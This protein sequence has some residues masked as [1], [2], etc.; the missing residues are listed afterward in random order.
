MGKQ[1]G[2]QA[3]NIKTYRIKSLGKHNMLSAI[4]HRDTHDKYMHRAFITDET[5][6]LDMQLMLPRTKQVNGELLITKTKSVLSKLMSYLLLAGPDQEENEDGEHD[7][8][9]ADDDEREVGDH[10]GDVQQLLD[11]CR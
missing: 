10:I 7:G 5:S 6:E 4:L 8:S 1:K 11:S 3:K 2:K 9:Q